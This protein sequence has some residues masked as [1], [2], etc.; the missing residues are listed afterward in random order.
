MIDQL[1]IQC[2]CIRLN[3]GLQLGAVKIERFFQHFIFCIAGHLN[4]P[5]AGIFTHH[6][7]QFTLILQPFF[8]IFLCINC[9]VQ[10][11]LKK[12]FQVLPVGYNKISR[13]KMA[14]CF[15]NICSVHKI[16]MGFNKTTVAETTTVVI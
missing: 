12:W 6:S 14:G 10:Q 9:S 15:L 13:N 11:I 16:N 2:I 4:L 5:P 1:F 8:Q 3:V 7:L